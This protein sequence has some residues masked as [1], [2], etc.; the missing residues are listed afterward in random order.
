MPTQLGLDL[1]GEPRA[2]VRHRQEDPRHRE[3]GVQL[4]V[5]GTPA[6]FINGRPIVGALPLLDFRMLIAEELARVGVK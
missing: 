4:R 6:Y 3:L 5:S 1:C 2:R